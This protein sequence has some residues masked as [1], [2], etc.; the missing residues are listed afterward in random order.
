MMSTYGGL[1]I[2]QQDVEGGH[3]NIDVILMIE[4]IVLQQWY[5][6]SD[7]RTERKLTNN[8][9]F[10]IRTDSSWKGSAYL[11]QYIAYFFKVEHLHEAAPPKGY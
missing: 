7:Q 9:S 5:S 1:T 2:Q 4:I 8:L 10:M 6:L 3:P 11:S